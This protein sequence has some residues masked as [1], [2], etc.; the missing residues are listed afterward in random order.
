[1]AIVRDSGLENPSKAFALLA[2]I[3]GPGA[4]T[5]WGFLLAPPLHLR[6]A[7]DELGMWRPEEA[8]SDID[9]HILE[10]LCA[11]LAAASEIE[12]GRIEVD[13]RDREVILEGTTRDERMT[14]A[15]MM[16]VIQVPGVRAV[17]SY[18]QTSPI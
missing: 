13:V 8:G 11:R 17:R 5:R 7:M 10:E 4:H 15:I 6:H 18:L 12:A 3:S 2:T 9:S 16:C 1:M 14:R